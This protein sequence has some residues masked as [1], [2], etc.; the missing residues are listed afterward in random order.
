M[1][2][3]ETQNL[4]KQII[5]LSGQLKKSMEKD[6]KEA[7]NQKEAVETPQEK[8]QRQ[9]DLLSIGDDIPKNLQSLLPMLQEVRDESIYHYQLVGFKNLTIAELFNV[10]SSRI[11]QICTEVRIQKHREKIRETYG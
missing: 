11:S 5:D 3:K 8:L 10:S 2:S 9:L 4:L 7:L 6:V 1:Y